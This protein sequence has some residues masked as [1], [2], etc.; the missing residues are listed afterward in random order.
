MRLY[1]LPQVESRAK[2]VHG[3]LEKLDEAQT[4]RSSNREKLKQKRYER[5]MKD[6]RRAVKFTDVL[7]AGDPH[8]HEF[9]EEM[10]DQKKDLYYKICRICQHRV[11]FEKL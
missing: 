11:E 4:T 1:L 5:K 2:E 7:L 8:Q 9:G 6:L 10:A 3:S